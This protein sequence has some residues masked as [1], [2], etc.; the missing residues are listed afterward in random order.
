[1]K[2]RGM[3]FM[4][5]LLSFLFVFSAF[6]YAALSDTMY[7][8]GSAHVEPPPV[9]DLYISDIQLVGSASVDYAKIHPTT[10]STSLSVTSNRSVT[11]RV[12][13][14]NN[15]DITY[16]YK[17]QKYLADI[18]SNGLIGKTN[19]ITITTKDSQN[20]T[21]NSFN[22]DDWVPPHTERVFYVTYTY[23]SNARGQVENLVNFAFGLH[24]DAIH[25]Q[26]LVVLNDKVSNYGYDFLAEAFDKK[27]KETGLQVLGNVGE[28]EEI[29]DAL[30][31]SDQ[32][33]DINGEEVPVKFIVCRENVDNKGA[34]GDA[35]KP[36]G[37]SGCEYTVY[38]T[39]DP[40]NSPSGKAEVFAV[41]YTC[42]KN[43]VWRQVGQLYQGEA[44]RCDYDGAGGDFVGGFDV[45]SWRA[46][47]ANYEIADGIT[48]L[49]GQEQGDQYDKY[50]LIEELMS[51]A[52]QDIFNMIDNTN[53]FK[54]VY[55]ILTSNPSSKPGSE[56]LRSAFDAAAPYYNNLNNGQ[57]FKVKRDCTRAEIIPFIEAIQEA[58][59]YYNEVN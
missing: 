58:L 18:G 23:G 53:I 10:V 2:R 38:I 40:L 51:A 33:I 13:V 39:V 45:E 3:T 30:F 26:F 36:S 59:D 24:M 5:L 22:T 43:G 1:M 56:G 14:C 6:G 57:E 9:F 28:E 27:Y 15:T 20:D 47:P 50:K 55:N 12:T 25:D 11:Y 31:G 44:N 21:Y 35:Y 48:Y 49:A 37:P 8:S 46:T 17:G 42:D 4:G 29:F 32:T 41:S 54:K 7:L 19:G 34:T 52:D 16:W